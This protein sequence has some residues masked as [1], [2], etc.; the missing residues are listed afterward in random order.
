[1]TIGVNARALHVLHTSFRVRYK[2][3]GKGGSA[4][5]TDG[6]ASSVIL[7]FFNFSNLVSTP[8]HHYTGSTSGEVV[9]TTPSPCNSK[10]KAHSFSTTCPLSCSPFLPAPVPQLGGS[11]TGLAP[12]P[13]AGCRYLAP[14]SA[15][16]QV[17]SRACS[18]IITIL[19]LTAKG[20]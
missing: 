9:L 1:M 19:D 17:L 8:L 15:D 5:L 16:H 13:A 3:A 7:L 4:S 20:H 12:G 14:A 2:G 6:I 11:D 18:P 10:T